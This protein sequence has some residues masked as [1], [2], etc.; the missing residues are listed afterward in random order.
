[1]SE[2]AVGRNEDLPLVQGFLVNLSNSGGERGWN[3]SL[4]GHVPPALNDMSFEVDLC[5]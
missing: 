1:M 3:K 5:G 4:R 2:E